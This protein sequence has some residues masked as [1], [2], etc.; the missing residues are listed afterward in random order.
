[1]AKRDRDVDAG[2]VRPAMDAYTGLL[3]LSLLALGGGAALLYLD[4]QQYP[5]NQPPAVDPFRPAVKPD[6]IA[7]AAPAAPMPPD[8]G[9]PP[10]AQPPA[11]N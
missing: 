2:T 3:A 9:M 8:G 1:M 5:T 10:A 6:A 11:Q 7:P 4:Y